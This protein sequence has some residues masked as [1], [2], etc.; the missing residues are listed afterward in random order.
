MLSVIFAGSIG[1][2]RREANERRANSKKMIY[3]S[4]SL[5]FQTHSNGKWEWVSVCAW[6][7]LK[8]LP[9]MSNFIIRKSHSFQM[10]IHSLSPPPQHKKIHK[11]STS[12]LCFTINSINVKQNKSSQQKIEAQKYIQSENEEKV[13]G[14][15]AVK[16]V[17]ISLLMCP[18]SLLSPHA[19]LPSLLHITTSM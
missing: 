4:F 15:R 16:I 11:F 10:G 19:A 3:N 17:L 5:P 7:F 2:Q 8:F 12:M 1:K 6:E 13:S 14:R 18:E 9:L